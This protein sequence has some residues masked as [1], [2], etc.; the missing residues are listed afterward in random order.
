MSKLP[1]TLTEALCKLALTNRRLSNARCAVSRAIGAGQST[2]DAR[3]VAEQANLERELAIV[4]VLC[5]FGSSI[6]RGEAVVGLSKEV[7][8]DIGVRG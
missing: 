8:R 2:E 3:Q 1:N 5:S 6:E 4:S 7:Q